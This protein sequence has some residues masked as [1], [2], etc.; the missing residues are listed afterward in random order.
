MCFA[1]VGWRTGFGAAG[2]DEEGTN[3]VLRRLALVAATAAMLWR[4]TPLGSWISRDFE[5]EADWRGLLRLAQRRGGDR[6]AAGAGEVEPRRA[7]I[8]EIVQ[9]WF[10]THPDALDRIGLALRYRSGER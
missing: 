9:V 6:P 8:P 4:P 3:L 2:R 10:G 1:V 7:P 5:R